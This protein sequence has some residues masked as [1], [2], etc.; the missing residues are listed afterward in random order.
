MNSILRINIFKYVHHEVKGFFEYQAHVP[1]TRMDLLDEIDVS[2]SVT[3]LR[4][5]VFW[6]RRKVRERVETETVPSTWSM[7]KLNNM[8][9]TAASP[10]ELLIVITP[11]SKILYGFW[12]FDRHC[13]I[14]NLIRPIR[15]FKIL[16]RISTNLF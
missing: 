9:A 8:W 14:T 6:N 4:I 13:S 15:L 11:N 12:S 16:M 3:I 2:R 7:D 10:A 5:V 1:C